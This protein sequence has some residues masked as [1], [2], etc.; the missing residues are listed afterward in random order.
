MDSPFL[1][2]LKLFVGDSINIRLAKIV[3]LSLP[4]NGIKSTYFQLDSF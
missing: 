2:K 4:L 3:I 1:V